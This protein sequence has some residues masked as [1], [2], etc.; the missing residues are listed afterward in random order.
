M[1]LDTSYIKT[2]EFNSL[3]KDTIHFI[4]LIM[5]VLVHAHKLELD[6]NKDA[7]VFLQQF[8]P[9]NELLE[10]YDHITWGLAIHNLISDIIQSKDS[11]SSHFEPRVFH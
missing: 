4:N 10:S 11:L 3:D 8:S 2:N 5:F 7:R 9:N 6:E 1:K